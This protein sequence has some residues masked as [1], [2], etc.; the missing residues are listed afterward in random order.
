MEAT[1]TNMALYRRGEIRCL[2]VKKLIECYS[3]QASRR[4]S[5]NLDRIPQPESRTLR[6]DF[7]RL[8]VPVRV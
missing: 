8:N 1:E 4:V 5:D 2:C 7:A 3:S 6:Y